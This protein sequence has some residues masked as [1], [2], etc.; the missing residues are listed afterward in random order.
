MTGIQF[1][2]ALKIAWTGKNGFS[3]M[4]VLILRIIVFLG[5]ENL[6]RKKG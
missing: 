2:S 5:L 1:E 6:P 4:L 3:Q